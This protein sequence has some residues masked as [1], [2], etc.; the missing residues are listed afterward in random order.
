MVIFTSLLFSFVVVVVVAVV[1][2][3]L[4]G[5]VFNMYTVFK[6]TSIYHVMKIAIYSDL[7]LVDVLS[8]FNG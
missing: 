5:Y 8:Q 4:F 1:G 7:F 3:L 2:F 6:H